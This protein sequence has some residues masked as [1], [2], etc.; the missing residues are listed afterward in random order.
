MAGILAASVLRGFTGFG[1]GL[2]AVPLLSLVLPPAEVVPLVVALQIVVGIGGL[3]DAMHL[4]DWRSVR[5]LVP[6]L[7]VGVP[8]GIAILTVLA[9]NPVRLLIGAMIVVS[10]VLLHRGARLP[11]EP[12]RV[13]TAAVGLLAGV[14]SGFSSMGGPPIIV[15][16][17]ARGHNPHRIRATAIVYFMIA[18][19]A[20]G[21]PMVVRGLITRHTLIWAAACL[22]V[23]FLGTWLGTLAF[24]RAKPRHHRL[25]ALITLTMLAT[26]LI[27]RTLISMWGA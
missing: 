3:R 2:A 4:C 8:T 25:T 22:P 26:L 16:L 18:G 20:T 19:C 1:F 13:L 10:V 6:G 12:S 5:Q 14:I 24:H 15:Y 11:P 21:L 23:L 7:I 17:M 27:G 9:P